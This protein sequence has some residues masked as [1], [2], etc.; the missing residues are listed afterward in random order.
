MT[1]FADTAMRKVCRNPRCGCKLPAPVSNLRE[2]FRAKRCHSQ[3]YRKRCL[4]CAEAMERKTENQSFVA[5][6][7][8]AALY[9]GEGALGANRC[10]DPHGDP[11][12]H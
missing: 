1:E 6:A 5:N 7:S 4:V 9:S 8:A 11:R 3:F 10:A 12:P 2:A